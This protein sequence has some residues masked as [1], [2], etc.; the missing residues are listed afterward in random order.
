MMKNQ[1]RQAIHA[2]A[3]P[4]WPGRSSSCARKGVESISVVGA[5]ALDHIL[6][7]ITVNTGQQ[8]EQKDRTP[9]R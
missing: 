4:E 6:Q 1:G 9:C 5:I 8:V 7:R 2:Y 3:G